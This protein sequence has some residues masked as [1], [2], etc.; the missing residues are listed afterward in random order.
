MSLFV[1][2]GGVC[3]GVCLGVG[4]YASIFHWDYGRK[5]EL[6]FTVRVVVVAFWVASFSFLVTLFVRH[7]I[8]VRDLQ[9][10]KETYHMWI[11]CYDAYPPDPLKFFLFRLF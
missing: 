3:W 5:P 4:V 9:L 10:A 6:K 1:V 8:N 7:A 11:N 2:V